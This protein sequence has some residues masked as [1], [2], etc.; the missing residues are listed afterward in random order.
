MQTLSPALV[1]NDYI[2]IYDAWGKKIIE[3]EKK[4]II[5]ADINHRFFYVYDRNLLRRKKNRGKKCNAQT[6]ENFTLEMFV[7]CGLKVDCF[8][9]GNIRSVAIQRNEKVQ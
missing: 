8:F 9:P 7:K 4:E 5:D 2:I 1:Y 6:A 3:N